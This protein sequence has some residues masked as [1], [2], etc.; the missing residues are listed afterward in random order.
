MDTHLETHSQP[1]LGAAPLAAG[2]EPNPNKMNDANDT[3]TAM[4]GLVLEELRGL[5]GDV[6]RLDGKVDQ[7]E[8]KVGQLDGK[9]GQLD[10]KVGRLEGKI[11]ELHGKMGETKAE[12]VGKIGE[13]HG[14]MGE[15]KAELVGKI[16]ETNVEISKTNEK[17]A[18]D[19]MQ[20][21][22]VVIATAAVMFAA[23]RYFG[24]G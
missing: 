5:R 10:G 21:I 13:L 16:G 3:T 20:I 4:L 2:G 1:P 18:N 15:T 12:L 19:K 9:V 8:G 7:L 17:M 6:A 22:S 14:K 11:G 24:V 23:L